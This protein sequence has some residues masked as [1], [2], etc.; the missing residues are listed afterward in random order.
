MRTATLQPQ[1]GHIASNRF[2][3]NPRKPLIL[4]DCERGD[5]NPHALRHWILSPA[6]LPFRHSRMVRGCDPGFI[7]RTEFPDK[8]DTIAA[9][10]AFINEQDAGTRVSDSQVVL[11]D[12]TILGVDSLKLIIT[13]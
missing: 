10:Q 1:F 8:F 3:H 12:R 7:V 2:S 4:L 11:R 5:L 9:R 6:R 13:R